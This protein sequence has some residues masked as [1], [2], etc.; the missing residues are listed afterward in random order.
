MKRAALLALA[1]GACMSQQPQYG[2]SPTVLSQ[3]VLRGVV[4]A[5]LQADTGGV[6][7]D[8]LFMVGATVVADGRVRVNH[9][10]FAGVSRDGSV[11]LTGYQ[12]EIASGLA[13]AIV[14]YRWVA[15]DGRRGTF[16]RATLVLEPHGD[17]W[18]IKHV[19]SSTSQ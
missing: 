4:T 12:A 17:G 2:V 6:G 1:V 7:G 10:Y 15:K 13:W 14:D 18:Q 11:T 8:T 16:A 19:H 9:P 5:A 3:R